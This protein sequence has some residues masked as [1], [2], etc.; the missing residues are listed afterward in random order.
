MFVDY[1]KR[2]SSQNPDYS[3]N[4]KSLYLE[5]QKPEFINDFSSLINNIKE[6]KKF[7]LINKEFMDILFHRYELKKNSFINYYTGNNNIIMDYLYDKNALLILFPL[8]YYNTNKANKVYI[9]NKTNNNIKDKQLYEDILK[10]SINYTYLR[11]NKNI[12]NFNDFINNKNIES[13]SKQND[14][15]IK[16]DNY[17]NQN[18]YLQNNPKINSNY[19]NTNIID[20]KY[21]N[22]NN[23]KRG[24][25]I[26]PVNNNKIMSSTIND[27][28]IRQ[29]Y[30]NIKPY[31]RKNNIIKDEVKENKNYSKY[32]NYS[33]NKNYNESGNYKDALDEMKKEIEILKNEKKQLEKDLSDK[34]YELKN[35]TNK[36]EK[37]IENKNK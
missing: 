33:L 14:I 18:K 5:N 29:K 27:T 1:K 4:Q 12:V 25:S 19:I 2:I 15:N 23:N 13:L 31:I 36:N 24:Y 34:E 16:Q 7:K 28:S 21:N 35:K 17:N 8:S 20:K 30:N 6:G 3:Q 9:I 22:I 37:E 32:D 26:D 11:K 10:N